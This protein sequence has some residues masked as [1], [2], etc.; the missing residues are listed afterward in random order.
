MEKVDNIDPTYNINVCLDGTDDLRAR[1]EKYFLNCKINYDEMFS[2]YLLSRI[3]NA[4][5]DDVFMI[6]LRQLAWGKSYF[7][8]T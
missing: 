7:Q 5:K 8:T 4:I 1:T 6:R 2:R 3:Y